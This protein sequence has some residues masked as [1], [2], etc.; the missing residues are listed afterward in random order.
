[1]T[2]AND[3]G[4][5][6][7]LIIILGF[8]VYFI[9]CNIAKKKSRQAADDNP[10]LKICSERSL[11]S[12]IDGYCRSRSLLVFST[13]KPG[14]IVVSIMPFSERRLKQISPSHRVRPYVVLE[15][16]DGY[17]T[18]YQSTS[19]IPGSNSRNK[20]EITAGRYNVWKDGWI[21][22][23][24]IYRVP[25]ENV[26]TVLD[27]LTIADQK[28]I[29]H[30]VAESSREN[31]KYFPI[32]EAQFVVRK[33]CVLEKDNE[34][35]YFWNDD[36]KLV[37]IRLEESG[38]IA[39]EFKSKAYFLKPAEAIVVDNLSQYKA[40]GYPIGDVQSKLNDMYVILDTDTSV[41]VMSR[42]DL[43]PKKTIKTDTF[44]FERP[45]G[46]V[47]TF[48]EHRYLYLYSAKDRC[49]ILKQY[50]I[51][52]EEAM[53]DEPIV[54]EIAYYD[55]YK[56]TDYV[57]KAE[58]AEILWDASARKKRHYLSDLIEIYNSQQALN[59]GK[60]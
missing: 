3:M 46:T 60:C 35:Y 21:I 45:I 51:S 17:F 15:V 31:K 9:A 59:T 37:L 54:D 56:P 28:Q 25:A 2:E 22:T 39:I 6:I 38:E 52:E 27:H 42:R 44:I 57:E 14:D 1:M 11:K 7:V 34:L 29:N 20:F 41:Q 5:V 53:S 43:P 55:L 8:A 47:L 30:I 16:K 49:G 50:G 40:A 13:L 32:P 48:C 36:S 12:L 58:L 33:G 26:M 19:H 10:R 4:A 18:A 23:D 24:D